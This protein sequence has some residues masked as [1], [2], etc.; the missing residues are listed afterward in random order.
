[1]GLTKPQRQHREL[2]GIK[3]WNVGWGDWGDGCSIICG[4]KRGGLIMG[5]N[6]K[7][8]KGGYSG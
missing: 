7:I 8:G 3:K 5:S 1:M 4:A 6:A 2:G